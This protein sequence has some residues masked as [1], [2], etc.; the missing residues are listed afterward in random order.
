MCRNTMKYTFCTS[1]NKPDNFIEGHP[2]WKYD[3]NWKQYW[4]KL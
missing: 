1:E 2:D 4:T 3:K